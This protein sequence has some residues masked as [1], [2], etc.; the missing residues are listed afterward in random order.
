MDIE[1]KCDII[2]EFMRDHILDGQYGDDEDV[3]EFLNYNDIGI[4]LS[5]AVSYSLAKLTTEG[6]VVVEETWLSLCN[7]FAVDPDGTYEDLFDFFG[8]AIEDEDE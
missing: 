7:I 2:E 6:T 4:P 1:T 8:E 5:Q 3:E